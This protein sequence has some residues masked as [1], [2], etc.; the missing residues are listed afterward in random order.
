VQIFGTDIDDRAIAIARL[1]RY[2]QPLA[3]LSPERVQRWFAEEGGDRCVVPEI[4]DM[5]NLLDYRDLQRDVRTVLRKLAPIE[6]QVSLGDGRM[7]FLLRLRPY[8]TVDNVIDGVVL[9]FVDVSERNAQQE[10]V[11]ASE[12]RY[13]MLFEVWTTGSRI[14]SPSSVEW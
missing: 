11:R 1:G 4:R 13:R 7:V 12:A 3:G 5:C 9:T 8:R 10:A 6:R 14:F 2:R